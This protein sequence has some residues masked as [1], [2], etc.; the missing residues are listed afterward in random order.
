MSSLK[1]VG[2]ATLIT[3]SIVSLL[4]SLAALAGVWIV[5]KPIKDAM[6]TGLLLASETLNVTGDALGVLDEGLRSTGQLVTQVEASVQSLATMLETTTPA[7][8]SVGDLLGKGVPATLTAA[9]TTLKAAQK[10]AEAVDG[11]LSVLSDLPLLGISYSPEVPLSLALRDISTSL[12]TLPGELEMLGEQVTASLNSLPTL[13]ST[14]TELAG[15]IGDIDATVDQSRQV[16]R[17]YQ[18]LALRYKGVVDFLYGATPAIT[19]IFPLLLSLLIFWIM[20][21]QVSTARKGW[22]WLRGEPV[23]A[24]LAVAMPPLDALPASGQPV[25]RQIEAPSEQTV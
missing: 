6:T 12:E 14:T 4:F 10:S 16:V 18:R 22:E 2:G 20:V 21:V 15:A 11:V 7:L 9:N 19:F 13:S 1:R 25:V 3:I 8:T 5:R 24:S 23:P 17:D